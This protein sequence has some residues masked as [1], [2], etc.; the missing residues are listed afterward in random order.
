MS[1]RG[2]VLRAL[3]MVLLVAALPVALLSSSGSAPPPASQV[4]AS[5]VSPIPSS[6]PPSPPSP[7]PSP[8]PEPPPE[9]P[10]VSPFTGLATDLGAPVLAVKIDNAARARPQTGLALADLV[11]VEPVEGGLSRLLAVYQSRFPPVVGPVRSTRLTD[12]QLLANFG[13]PALAFSGD[14]AEVGALL[15]R[16][17]VLDVSEEKQRRS[18]RRDRNRR[19]PNN[20]YG[21]TNLLRRGGAPPRD[22]GFR[23]GPT[24]PGGRPVP[25]TNVRYRATDIG[26]QWVPAEARWVISMDGAPLTSAAG[27]RP[28]AATVVLQRVAVRD[29]PIRDAFGTPSPFAST[30]GGGSVV[31]LRD[32]LAFNGSWSRPAPDAITTFALPDGSP[33]TFA[34]GPVWVV[35]VPG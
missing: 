9:P 1:Q 24:P 31:V 5:P 29:T 34:P 30:V 25:G 10:P 16:A 13:R 32:G 22:I 18:Y 14:A 21:D 4:A 19:M 7:L 11:Y 8:S 2:Y 6:A 28:G 15:A 26:V 35:L 27:P 23:F 20:L 17:P 12:L 3:V 33:L